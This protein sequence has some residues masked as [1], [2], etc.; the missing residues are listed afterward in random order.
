[1][2]LIALSIVCATLVLLAFTG[3]LFFAFKMLANTISQLC[4][5]HARDADT[6]VSI[7]TDSREMCRARFESDMGKTLTPPDTFKTHVPV[8]NFDPRPEPFDPDVPNNGSLQPHN[9]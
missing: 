3:L 7:N 6:I 9:L 8:R 2:E 5:T 1:M 4:C